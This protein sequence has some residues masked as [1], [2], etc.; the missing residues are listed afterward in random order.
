IMAEPPVTYW[1]LGADEADPWRTAETW[2][3]AEA[4]SQ[5]LYFAAGPAGSIDSSNDGRLASRVPDG[6]ADVRV[7]DLTTTTGL[8]NRWANLYGGLGRVAAIGGGRHL[9]YPDMADND[10]HGLTYTSSALDAPVELVGHPILHLWVEAE[11]EV[12]VFCHL[13]EVFSDG[14]SRYLS[15]GCLRSSHR[16]E[17]EPPDDY[18]G[19]PWH[20]SGHGDLIGPVDGPMTLAFDLQPVGTVIAAESCLRVTITGAELASHE[21]LDHVVAPS[22]TVLFG[23]KTPSR[24]EL[25]VVRGVLV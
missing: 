21:P 25:P 5:P 24:I 19:M 17:A 23:A 13:E 10:R 16:A 1:L 7:V 4:P 3:V 14:F 22:I 8:A 15:E 11:T 6:G 2:P 18:L 20:P 12:D 9:G